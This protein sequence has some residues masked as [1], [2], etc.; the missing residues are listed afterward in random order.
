MKVWLI[1]LLV[2]TTVSAQEKPADAPPDMEHMEHGDQHGG[3]MRSGMHYAVAKGVTLETKVDDVTH[4]ITLREGPI[5]LPANTSHMKMPQPPDLHWTI[6]MNAW[7]L[8]YSPRLVD[9]NG[10]EVS[11]PVLHHTA[12]WNENRVDFLCPN[13]EEH[14]F[15]AG[16][17]MTNWIQVPGYGYRVQKSDQ[18]RIETM[19]HNPTGTS[20]ENVF[21]E[22]RI[23]YQEADVPGPPAPKNYYPAWIDVKSCGDSSYDLKPGENIKQGVVAVNYSGVLLGVGGHMHDYAKRIVLENVSRNQTVAA[24]D[25]KVDSKG[26]L[27]SMPTVTFFDQGGYKLAAG[28][29]LKTSA[30][31]FN[32]T[33]RVL[34]NG[35]MGIIVGYFVPDDDK[36][37]AA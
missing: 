37:M 26:Q 22:V 12:F 9:A 11:S 25:A 36:P 10:K 2:A 14:I 7:L 35:A 13:K 33:G 34:R 27:L 30:T 31:Y 21:L 32:P 8:A 15:G 29:A 23:P 6:P 20:Y 17:E 24:L 16:S 3:F 1:C 28:D 4:A 18:I 5:N 19:V